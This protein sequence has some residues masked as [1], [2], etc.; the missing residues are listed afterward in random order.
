MPE[1]RPSD[2]GKDKAQWW[3]N[4]SPDQM[5]GEDG[6]GPAAYNNQN[7]GKNK[8]DEEMEPTKHPT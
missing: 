8:Y 1:A 2:Q 4:A 3:K 6:P 7:A 5:E